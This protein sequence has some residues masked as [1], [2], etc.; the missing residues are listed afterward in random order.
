M[1]WFSLIFANKLTILYLKWLK[2]NP[3]TIPTILVKTFVGFVQIYSYCTLQ[4][5]FNILTLLNPHIPTPYKQTQNK[6][7]KTSWNNRITGVFL[8]RLPQL[9]FYYRQ[10]NEQSSVARARHFCF[11][12]F[13]SSG[14][15]RSWNY[16][17]CIYTI[18]PP[19]WSSLQ[20]ISTANF[21]HCSSVFPYVYI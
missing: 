21:L 19:S 11:P 20:V 6:N 15:Q 4:T 9:W 10:F 12:L 8:H 16:R 3:F 17:P 7:L 18:V 13:F 5:Y 1:W 14:E 2:A